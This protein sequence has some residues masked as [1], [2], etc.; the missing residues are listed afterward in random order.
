MEISAVKKNKF[1]FIIGGAIVLMVVFYYFFTNSYR[2]DA[3]KK[4]AG[5]ERAL[6]RL[7]VY[8]RKGVKIINAKWKPAE[9]VKLVK[10]KEK[11]LS[12]Y[13]ELSERDIHIEKIFSTGQGEEIED[14]AIWKNMYTQRVNLLNDTLAKSNVPASEGALPFRDW[15]DGIPTWDEIV[16]EQKRYWIVEELLKIILKENLEIKSLGIVN[17]RQEGFYQNNASSEF[18]EFVPFTINVSMDIKRILFLLDALLQSKFPLEIEA[19]N[20]NKKSDNA[21]DVVID[22]FVID[23]KTGEEST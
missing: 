5:M 10:V 18:Y 23:F 4:E 20:I 19:V 12:K 9:E 17:F 21:V 6:S 22:A 11:K 1:W 8:K 16:K 14:V 7:E 3:S 2:S 13:K 15:G